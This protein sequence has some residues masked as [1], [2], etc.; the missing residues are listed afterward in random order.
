MDVETDPKVEDEKV[1]RAQRLSHKLAQ[2]T[3]IELFALD[4]ASIWD[5]WVSLLSQTAFPLETSSR[6]SHFTLV[7]Q[8]VEKVISTIHSVI[9]WLAYIQLIRLFDTLRE[10]IRK[11]RAYEIHSRKRGISDNSIAITIY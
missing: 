10:T 6:D 2:H 8:A 9:Q 3:I 7:F 4:Y 1:I 11:Q 5:N